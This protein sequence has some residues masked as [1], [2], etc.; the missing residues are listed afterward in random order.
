MERLWATERKES[1]EKSRINL[2]IGEKAG[3]IG[4]NE[5]KIFES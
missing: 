4:E 3:F 2:R 1:K 5:G